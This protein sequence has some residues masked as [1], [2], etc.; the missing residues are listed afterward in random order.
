MFKPSVALIVL[1]G[2]VVLALSCSRVVVV[3]RHYA[4]KLLHSH[5]LKSHWG[6]LC[7]ALGIGIADGGSHV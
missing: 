1:A 4:G 5:Y 3:E 2:V 6:H 7:V